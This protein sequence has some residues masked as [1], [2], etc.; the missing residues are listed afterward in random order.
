MNKNTL[1]IGFM[2]FAI[3]FG[4]GNLIFPPKLGLESGMDFWSSISGFVITGV[5]LPL[6][7]IIVSAFYE[8]GYKAVLNKVH[9]LFSLLFLMAI[10]LAIGPFFA[11]PRTAAT[12][13]EFAVL[14]FVSESNSTYLLIFTVVYF[15][16]ALW[17]SLNP[18]K[19]VE[20]IGAILTPALL[21]SIFALIVASVYAYAHNTPLPVDK[22]SYEALFIGMVEGYNTMDALASVAFAVIVL[23][24]IKSKGI[25]G[26]AMI[27]QTIMAGVIAAI[28]LGIIYVALGWI[29]NHI[30]I[31]QATLT[32]LAADGKNIGAFILNK[33]ASDSFGIFG[34]ALLGLIV[35]LACLTTTIGLIVS[36]SEYFYEVFPKISYKIYAILF[37]LIGFIIANQ[38]LN[39]VISK[40]VP[41]LLVLYPITMTVI[42][43]LLVN[44]F[45]NIP[46]LAQRI[47][48]GLVTVTSILSVAGVEFINQLPLKNYSMEW[49]LPAVIGC[50]IGYL[51]SPMFGK[52]A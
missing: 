41:V 8:G 15:V 51:L 9:P 25:S 6:L 32:Q 37:T 4:A 2:L 47:S 50:I 33:A 3:F 36:V 16:L 20:R 35:T 11:I 21:L 5:G 38:G 48:L 27:S 40:S 13:F 46:L 24:A 7:G 12:S 22:D 31:K 30:A 19:M 17:L 29:G 23:S 49:L 14:P 28:A 34:G 18:S 45:V 52:K 43:L 10:Y 39:V 1:V 44:L 42:L 26:K